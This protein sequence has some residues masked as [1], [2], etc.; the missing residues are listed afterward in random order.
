MTIEAVFLYWK[1]AGVSEEDDVERVV[2]KA[3]VEGF[4]FTVAEYQ[5]ALLRVR[6]GELDSTELDGVAGGA[7]F[8]PEV[9][10]EVVVGFELGEVHAPFVVGSVWKDKD[11]PPTER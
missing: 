4:A 10:D 1:R 6:Q 9:D 5:S 3:A 2:A 11:K 7:R 8:I